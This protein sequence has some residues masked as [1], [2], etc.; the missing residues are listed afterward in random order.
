MSTQ[1]GVTQSAQASTSTI[2]DTFDGDTVDIVDPTIW[3]EFTTD[4]NVTIVQRRSR[5]EV[6]VGPDAMRG[7][8][9]NQIDVHVGT[10]CR[11]PG[12]FDARVDFALIEW[13]SDDKVF[14]G[15]NAFYADSAVGRVSIS[16]FDGYSSWILP[17]GHTTSVGDAHAGSLRIERV[18][19]ALKTY[20][21]HRDGWF[22]LVA[23]RSRKDA[24]LGLQAMSFGQDTQFGHKRVA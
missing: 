19:G 10:R 7:G 17:G 4:A 2:T 6:S 24:V 20:V 13:P 1:N 21:W 12:D 5:L 15:L 9:Y 11:F 18:G 22:M 8:E 14:V 3:N 23:G 16:A